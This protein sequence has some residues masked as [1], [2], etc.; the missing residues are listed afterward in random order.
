MTDPKLFNRVHVSNYYKNHL[1]S[2]GMWKM[3]DKVRE[4]IKEDIAG[5]GVPTS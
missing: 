1:C 5:K 4:N 3:E 2:I